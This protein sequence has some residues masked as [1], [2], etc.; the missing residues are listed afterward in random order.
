M[1]GVLSC[2]EVQGEDVV[3]VSTAGFLVDGTLVQVVVTLPLLVHSEHVHAGQHGVQHL[4][5]RLQ[6]T[7]VTPVPASAVQVQPIHVH[8][9]TT[10]HRQH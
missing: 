3:E 10:Q 8:T 1:V 9:C 5:W 6:E 2:A 7:S 4:G